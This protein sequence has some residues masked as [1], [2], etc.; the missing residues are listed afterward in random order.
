LPW[1]ASGNSVGGDSPEE[2][3]IISGNE[4]FGVVISDPGTINNT[5]VGNFIGT[6]VTG[7]SPLPNK[8]AGVLLFQVEFNRIGGTRPGERNVISGNHRAGIEIIHEDSNLVLGNYIGTN[9]QGTQAVGNEREGV[10]ISQTTRLN[11]V[12]GATP[13]ERD[14]ISG[15]NQAGV[16]IELG[17]TGYNAVLGNRIGTDVS[18]TTA[19]GNGPG[20]R[21]SEYSHFN[22]VQSNLVSGNSEHGVYVSD[23]SHSS[24][25]RANR[26]GTAANGSTPLPNAGDGVLVAA[27]AN[28]I[29]GRQTEDGNIIAHNN[30]YGVEVKT[31][32]GNTIRRNSIYHNTGKGIGLIEGGNKELKAPAI[33]TVT[34]TSVSGK[35]CPG[36]KVEIFSDQATQ[37]RI[38][39]G[40]ATADSSGAFSF[41]SAAA[42]KGP[43]VTSTAIDRKG[44]TSEFSSAKPI[45]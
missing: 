29:G 18:G 37:G 3:N 24:M 41:K 11:I 39:E 40:V 32:P 21:I 38:Y 13:E 14:I 23:G 31:H 8:W 33:G 16:L 15:N 45:P 5:V 9:Y 26:I 7:T 44:N 17:S 28:L 27:P 10:R 43:Y 30:G 22:Y 36:C 34:K 19:L 35:A 2:R 25:L 4:L 6:D 1:Q 12:G 20:V 42:L